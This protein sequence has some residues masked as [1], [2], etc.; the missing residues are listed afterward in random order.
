MAEIFIV[1]ND[2][3]IPD[4]AWTDVNVAF[5]RADNVIENGNVHRIP[6]DDF[7]LIK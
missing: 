2:D 6:L 4:S 5:D 7:E 1:I 3:K